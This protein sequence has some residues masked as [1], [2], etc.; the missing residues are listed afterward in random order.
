MFSGKI[1]TADKTFTRPPVATV[2]TNSKSGLS[3][4]HPQFPSHSD[5]RFLSGEMIKGQALSMAVVSATLPSP[6]VHQICKLAEDA[7]PGNSLIHNILCLVLKLE[8]LFLCFWCTQSKQKCGTFPLSV[9]FKKSGTFPLSR[10]SQ[11]SLCL[12][13]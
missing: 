6:K 13:G 5:F 9:P 4:Y 3:L 1:Y 7:L 2:A 10:P 12:L 8:T 11:T